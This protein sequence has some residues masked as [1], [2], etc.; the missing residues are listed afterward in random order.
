MC[1]TFPIVLI[2]LIVSAT[3]FH[4]KQILSALQTMERVNDKND[5]LCQSSRTSERRQSGAA[6]PQ[7]HFIIWD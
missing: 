2:P 7:F 5:N 3:K 6:V 4:T 1:R